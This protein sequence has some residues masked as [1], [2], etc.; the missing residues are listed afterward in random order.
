MLNVV[1]RSILKSFK[2][3]RRHVFSKKNRKT[4]VPVLGII[5]LFIF[6]VQ[7]A[8]GMP[9]KIDPQAYTPLLNII[10]E[11]ESKGNYNAYFGNAA[12]SD[13]SFTDMSISEVLRWQDEFVKSGQPSSAVGRYQIIRPTLNGLVKQ[14][15]IKPG[16][17]F[18]EELQDKMA[19]TL[20]ERRGS[21]NFVNNKLSREQFAANIA[22]EWAALPRII[23]QHP[24]ESYYAGDGLNKARVNKEVVLNA[25]QK[26]KG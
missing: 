24:D 19:I 26:L 17:K 10:A 1:K 9:R 20:L 6:I 8:S 18:T 15:D 11:G 12:N 3:T 16:E 5:L 2:R 25:I 21:L 14:M 13:I 4:Y 7:Y 23:G 22:K